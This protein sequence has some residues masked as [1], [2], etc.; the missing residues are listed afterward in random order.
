MARG[1]KVTHYIAFSTAD[2]PHRR[3]MADAAFDMMRYDRCYPATNTPDGWI[4]FEQ[5]HQDGIQGGFTV[6]RWESF[7]FR[8]P[9][10]GSR[11]MAEGSGIPTV[12]RFEFEKRE[13]N[14]ARLKANA[15]M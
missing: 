9:V 10:L 6:A 4:V 7:G 13:A 3:S 12:M 2:H 1:G 14:A 8:N 11:G 15:S 5:P